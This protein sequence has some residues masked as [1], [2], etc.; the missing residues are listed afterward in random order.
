MK[1]QKTIVLVDGDT[2]CFRPAAASESRTVEVLHKPSG[3]SKIF[4]TRTAFKEHLKQKNFEYKPEDYEFTDIQTEEDISHPLHSI[5]SQLKSLRNDLEAD[6]VRIFIGG[7][8]NFREKLPFP[9]KYKGHRESMLRPVHLTE[10]KDYCVRQLGAELIDGKEADDA[11]IYVGNKYLE[12]GYKVILA[13][14]DKDAWAYS[15]FYIYNFTEDNPTLWQISD[16]GKLY[17]DKSK[18]TE[19]VKGEG[20]LWYCHQHVLGDATDNMNPRSILGI[21]WGEKSSL[22][23]LENCKTKQE[24]FDAVVNQYKEWFKYNPEYVDCHGEK[25]IATPH[26]MLQLYFRGIRMMSHPNDDLD[27]I[28]FCKKEGLKYEP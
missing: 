18:K 27:L 23:L 5:K 6:E 15:G 8:D 13:S 10:C 1:K 22:K 20:F 9:E 19:K 3:R 16:F 11:L 12:K 21:K 17:L 4:T 26:F 25:Q 28:E 2:L 24:A 7:K 14:Q